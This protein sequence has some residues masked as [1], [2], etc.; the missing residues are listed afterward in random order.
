MSGR[1]FERMANFSTTLPIPM[2]EEIDE[3]IHQGRVPSRSQ[4]I[5]EAVKDYLKAFE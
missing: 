2:L 3:L 1:K 5:R 4:V